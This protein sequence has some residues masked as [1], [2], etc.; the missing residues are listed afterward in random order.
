MK[1]YRNRQQGFTLIEL[2]AVI[3][4]LGILA[5]TALPRFISLQG[6]A[7]SNVLDGVAAAIQGANVQVYAKS[8]IVG[9]SGIDGTD[10]SNPQVDINGDG[11]DDTEVSFGYVETVS[12]SGVVDISGDP[13]IIIAAAAGAAPSGADTVVLVGYDL[14]ADGTIED[15]NCYITYTEA[16]A[17]GA[18]LPTPVKTDDTGCGG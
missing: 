16:A 10:A 13:D 4:L 6:D 15:D 17:A 3:V 12:L 11:V 5:V 18:A 7:R 8:L 2:V 9:N 14:D 1:K